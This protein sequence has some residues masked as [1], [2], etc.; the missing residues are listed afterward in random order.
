MPSATKPS[1]TTLS[2]SDEFIAKRAP[3]IRR[4]EALPKIRKMV[5]SE[6]F[7]AKSGSE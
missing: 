6:I 1:S 7:N 2:R 4:L 5:A 3:L